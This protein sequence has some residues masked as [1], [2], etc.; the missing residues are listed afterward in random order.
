MFFKNN[1]NLKLLLMLIIVLGITFTGLSLTILN[2]QNN[3]LAKMSDRVDE[4][5]AKSGK[6]TRK[7]FDRLESRVDELLARM[8]TNTAATI[9]Q[10]TGAALGQEEKKIQKGM[11][12]LLLKNAQGVTG[13]LNSVTPSAIMQKNYS[14][15]VKYSKAAAQ[16]EEIVYTLFFDKDGEPLPGFLNG[17]D[18]RIR[19]YVKTG[20]GDTKIQK[21]VSQSQNDPGVI[22][23]EQPIEYFGSVQ[24]KI[25]ICISR[26]SVIEE[27][28]QLQSRFNDLNQNTS[29]RI[30]TGLETGSLALKTEMQKELATITR[31][32]KKSI[33]NTHDILKKT[34]ASVKSDISSLIIIVGITSSLLILILT[35]LVLKLMV[36]N[37][38]NKISE[39]LRDTAQGEGDLTR[40]LSTNREDEIGILAHWFDAFL[41]RLNT[42]IIDIRANADTV[43]GA[44]EEVLS[45]AAQM[46]ENSQGLSGRANTVAAATE[47]MSTNMDSVAAASEQASVN[48]VTVS[49]SAGQM[50]LTLDEVAQSCTRA[51]SVTDNAGNSARNATS[52]VEQ[53]GEAAQ[54]ISKVTEVITEIAEQT[55]LLALN[56]T[57]EAARAGEEGKGFAVVASEIK[58][59][60][61]QTAQA[62]LNIKEKIQGI[63]I[64]TNETVDEVG[65]I[66]KVITEVNDIVT[67]IAG[68]VEEQ[69]AAA[70]EVAENVSQ[71]SIGIEEVNENV[72]Q[73]SLVST[74]IARDL[75]EVNTVAGN[76]SAGSITMETKAKELSDLSSTLKKMIGMFKVSK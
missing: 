7:D 34:G 64:S 22:V 41:E 31:K 38:I 20:Q 1:L 66:T 45:A 59:L 10:D 17:R 63:Q 30:S 15:L 11:E 8:K 73:S 12:S 49:D 24:G 29:T 48:M 42:I 60:S 69:T 56:A 39:G 5:L 26:N 76:I 36:I 4:A 52:K 28:K 19:Q 51:R 27:I 72:A 54:E 46:N 58:S 75:S 3:L 57:I 13:I 2:R 32:N 43:A 14:E 67:A 23:F 18:E 47:E 74:E 25:V 37:P 9:S 16:T 50:K 62:T 61:T 55:N 6:E 21:V 35:A 33:K 70:G 65:N 68:A 71:A 44:S 40:R 53:L